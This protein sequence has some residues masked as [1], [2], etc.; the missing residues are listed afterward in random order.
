MQLG[1][2]LL[3]QSQE[4]L[5]DLLVGAGV[6]LTGYGLGDGHKGLGLGDSGL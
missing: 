1:Q 6:V 5:V 2:V 3:A 4:G